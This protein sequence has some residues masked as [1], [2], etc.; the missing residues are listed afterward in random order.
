MKTGIRKSIIIA[1]LALGASALAAGMVSAQQVEDPL[2]DLFQ[3]TR[4]STPS[5]P[6]YRD[7]SLLE[8]GEEGE[9]AEN[10]FTPP[11]LAPIFA[12]DYNPDDYLL[13]P[14]DEDEEGEELGAIEVLP[15]DETELDDGEIVEEEEEQNLLE[16]EYQERPAVL[17]RGLDK[18]TGR[19]TDLELAVGDKLIFGGLRVTA[20][21]CHQTP[22]TEPPESVAYI[23]VEDYG[24]K[25]E[26]ETKLS[27]EIDQE[28]RVFHGWM[29]ASS[30]GLNALENAIYDVWVIRC[31]ADAPVLSEG[32]SES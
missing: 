17:L 16:Y 31:M 25:V 13:P 5:D 27:E 26:D 11:R 23:E 21:A 9:E 1:G 24:F 4:P 19:S 30:P 32:E 29:F 28:K 22:P 12:P 15:E 10:D 6:A 2:A 3:D 14:P 8:M 20:K 18:I 7:D